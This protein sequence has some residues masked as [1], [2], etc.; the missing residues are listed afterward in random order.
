MTSRYTKT[1]YE[2]S[3]DNNGNF[4]SYKKIK[5]EKVPG[6]DGLSGTVIDVL[7]MSIHN[8]FI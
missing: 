8:S 6:P 5:P 2:W 7:K 4:R 1:D 3:C